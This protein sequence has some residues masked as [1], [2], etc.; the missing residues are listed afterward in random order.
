M[1]EKR[2]ERGSVVTSPQLMF[3][4]PVAFPAGV[5]GGGWG[6]SPKRGLQERAGVRLFFSVGDYFSISVLP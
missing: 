5:E 6:C 2:D 1:G 3:S 4:Y